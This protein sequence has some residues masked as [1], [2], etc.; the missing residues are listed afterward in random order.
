MKKHNVTRMLSE[1][2]ILSLT[3]AMVFC[4]SNVSAEALK[5]AQTK[6]EKI[7]NSLN[8]AN[9]LIESLKTSKSTAES[10]A[11]AL[12]NQISSLESENKVAESELYAINT[13]IENISSTLE[14]TQKDIEAKK[15]DMSLRIVYSYENGR[16]KLLNS[17]FK[18]NSFSEFLN[19]FQY[20]VQVAKYDQEVINQYEQA[21]QVFSEQ[22]DALSEKQ[23]DAKRIVDE[24]KDRIAAINALKTAQE[25]EVVALEGELTDAREIAEV[26]EKEMQAQNEVLAAIQAAMAKEM[27]AEGEDTEEGEV[28]QNASEFVWPCPS[29]H[30]ITS[31][32]GMRESPTAGA[33][34]N[35]KGIDVGAPT[36][37]AIVA[38]Q[39]G[40]VL[41]ATF[42]GSA[43][44]YIILS[45]GKNSS[46]RL[47]CTVYMHASKLF[48]SEGQTVEKGQQI[49]AV[50]STGYSTGP[51]LHFGVSEDGVYVSPWGYVN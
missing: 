21:V 27:A 9:A 33:S 6:K 47:V 34:T 4:G 18:A 16:T 25:G 8:E 12:N 22:T 45:H 48:V 10:K 32:F 49:A 19:T 15:R 40:K 29:S 46:G 39:S 28:I 5:E 24:N 23:K 51:H 38:A 41:V 7:Q 11:K 31:N 44:N 3:V 14:Q 26:Y 43:G 36:G 30:R 1:I 35:H 13:D 42:S 20:A 2:A 37:S 17:L 50:G